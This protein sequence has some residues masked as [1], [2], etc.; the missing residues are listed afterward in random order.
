MRIKTLFPAFF[1]VLVS[2][3][4][5][6]Q[7]TGGSTAGSTPG[8]A[9]TTPGT[10]TATPGTTGTIPGTTGTIPGT[11]GTIPGTTR[12]PPAT[13]DIP[14][15][16]VPNISPTTELPPATAQ[17]PPVTTQLPPP[18]TGLPD[19]REDNTN[20]T[21]RLGGNFFD[22]GTRGDDVIVF[23]NQTGRSGT[24]EGGRTTLRG[25][26]DGDIAI[27][28]DEEA[29]F[30]TEEEDIFVAG[31]ETPDTLDEGVFRDDPETPMD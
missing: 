17:M 7:V 22:D 3:N 27:L 9:G 28:G 10:T 5:F 6:A 24:L 2:V 12:M 14:P 21:G 20:I 8:T 1:F 15:A 26:F 23:D 16:T 4:A 13:A 11:T 25:R 18:T 31:P 29:F 30:G 19:F